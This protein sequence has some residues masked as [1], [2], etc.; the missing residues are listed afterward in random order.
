MSDCKLHQGLNYMITYP[1]NLTDNDMPM[2]QL[3]QDEVTSDR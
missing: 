2:K 3:N 1:K